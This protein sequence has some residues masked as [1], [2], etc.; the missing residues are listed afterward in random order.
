MDTL[1][2]SVS[3]DLSEIRMVLQTAALDA[4]KFFQRRRPHVFQSLPL[5]KTPGLTNTLKNTM[6]KKIGETAKKPQGARTQ[7]RENENARQ[8]KRTKTKRLSAKRARMRLLWLFARCTGSGKLPAS[9]KLAHLNKKMPR[10]NEK[11][12][13]NVPSTH[14]ADLVGPNSAILRAQS[15]QKTRKINA[16]PTVLSLSH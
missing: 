13:K 12:S 16:T 3:G 9:E 1:P 7:T 4:Q 11:S 10:K 5:A 14:C 6:G 15:S 8:R 2:A